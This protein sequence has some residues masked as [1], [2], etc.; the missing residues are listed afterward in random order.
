MFDVIQASTVSFGIHAIRFGLFVRH[1]GC[2][3]TLDER[4]LPAQISDS[5]EWLL[6]FSK[7]NGTRASVPLILIEAQNNSINGPCQGMLLTN[8][9]VNFILKDG[10]S[11]LLPVSRN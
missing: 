10:Y 4:S 11:V 1:V 9:G 2:K 6:E 8:P 5:L 7:P 3:Q